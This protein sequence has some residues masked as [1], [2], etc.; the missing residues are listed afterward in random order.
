M[1]L[2][3]PSLNADTFQLF[4]DAFAQACPDRVHLLLWENSGAQTG[5]RLRWPANVQPAWLPPYWPELNP[6]A[7][8]WRDLKDA[9]AW[10]QCPNLDVQQDDIAM[11]LQGYEAATLQSLTHYT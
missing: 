3:L 1:F 5:H 10:L 11:L 8:V 7:R 6:I 9:R 2:E 4:V